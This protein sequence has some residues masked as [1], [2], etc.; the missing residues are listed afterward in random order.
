MASLEWKRGG[1][2]VGGG[3]SPR[4][5]SVAIVSALALGW[6]ATRAIRVEAEPPGSVR[7]IERG[8]PSLDHAPSTVVGGQEASRWELGTEATFDLDYASWMDDSGDGSRL[9]ST[10]ASG[11]L[12]LTV[13]ES[14]RDKRLLA[15]NARGL[16]TSFEGSDLELGTARAARED[17]EHP[18]FIELA[19]DGAVSGVWLREGRHFRAGLLMRSLAAALQFVSPDDPR[20]SRWSTREV[21]ANGPFVAHYARV[22]DLVEKRKDFSRPPPGMPAGARPSSLAKYALDRHG[23]VERV[24]LEETA[25]IPLGLASFETRNAVHLRL[26][27]TRRTRAVAPDLRGYV[28]SPLGGSDTASEEAQRR[29]DEE[30]ARGQ[31]F[32]GLTAKLD[33]LRPG[34]YTTEYDE[35]RS[36]LVALLRVD[37]RAVQECLEKLQ[38]NLDR[39]ERAT[40][41]GALSEAGTPAAQDALVN[42]AKDP[43]VQPDT[44]QEALINVSQ[45]EA[46]SADTL[47]A[48]SALANDDDRGIRGQAALALGAAARSAAGSADSSASDAAR[49]AA[50]DL[51]ASFERAKTADEQMLYA[52][53]LGNAGG[54]EALEVSKEILDADNPNL[55]ARGANALRFVEGPEADTLLADA[56]T[57]DTSADVRVSALSAVQYRSYTDALH[58][59]VDTAA[60]TDKDVSVRTAALNVLIQHADSSMSA[61]QT[62]SWMSQHDPDPDLRAAA[63]EALARGT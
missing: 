29:E 20:A 10:T 47:R 11:S 45:T 36:R 38:G 3:A 24:D 60:R 12:I 35:A 63:A 53:A 62:L 37:A 23:F 14:S 39:G 15:V 26:R 57:R 40:L 9:F 16:A 30:L 28:R 7:A 48:I 51:V 5:L 13:V 44:R 46:P 52:T 34:G 19:P 8:E 6:G 55:R 58:T 25:G 50:S 1:V 17:L 49:L 33:E 56:V 2:R 42:L 43:A 27:S 41:L 22:G 21:D 61:R 32:R 31:T 59:A 18:F 4:R 54:P